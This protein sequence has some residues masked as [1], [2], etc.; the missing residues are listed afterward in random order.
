MFDFG[1][2]EILFIA[3]VAIVVVGPKELPRALR[4]VGQWMSK[5]RRMAGDFQRQ[6]NEAI[7]EADLDDVKKSV[8]D[9]GRIDPIGNVRKEIAKVATGIKSDLDKASN[10]DNPEMETEGKPEKEAAS[11]TLPAAATPKVDPTPAEAAEPAPAEAPTKAEPVVAAGTAE[12]AVA[13]APAAK[14]GSAEP[15]KKPA[16]AAKAKPV[17]AEPTAALTTATAD[18]AEGAKP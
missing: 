4:T 15:A 9:I 17:S 11:P 2:T 1:W 14:P 16:P 8:T 12:P 7:R 10:L 3:V 18:V 13:P 5:A 6:F